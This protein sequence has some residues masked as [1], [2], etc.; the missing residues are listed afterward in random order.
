MMNTKTRLAISLAA[1]ITP[2]FFAAGCSSTPTQSDESDRYQVSQSAPAAENTAV[3]DDDL[4]ADT[5]ANDT[6][7]DENAMID[8][9]ISNSDPLGTHEPEDE[10]QAESETSV[11]DE[12]AATLEEIPGPDADMDDRPA[13]TLFRF[14]FDKRELSEQDKD[15]VIQHGEFLAQHPDKKIQL[16]GH[17]DAQGDPAYNQHLATQRANYVAGLLKAQGVSKEQIEIYSW[18][19]DKPQAN[20]SGWKD[21]RRVELFYEESLMVNAQEEDQEAA[22]L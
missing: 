18:G 15:I 11:M 19:S 5:T 16:H 22:S 1:I 17:A 20:A 13:L 14:G 3:T 8:A 21:N 9:L 4:L 2:A 6:I 12:I 7:R 10:L